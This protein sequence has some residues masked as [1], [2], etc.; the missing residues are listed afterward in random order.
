[1]DEE[2]IER[3]VVSHQEEMSE[4]PRKLFK[5]GLSQQRSA[6]DNITHP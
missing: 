2:K 3:D 6:L 1:M 4:L 5:I